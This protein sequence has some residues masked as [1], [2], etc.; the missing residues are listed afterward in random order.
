MIN[1][2]HRIAI[3]ILFAVCV[4]SP[5]VAYGAFADMEAFVEKGRA[6]EEEGDIPMAIGQY[7]VLANGYSEKSPKDE[8]RKYSEIFKHTG[9]LCV[10]SQRYVESLRFY[11]L[12]LQAA[13]QADDTELMMR[14]LGNIGNVYAMFDDF[15]RAIT[16]YSRCYR[17]ALRLD[18]P[19]LQAKSLYSLCSAYSFAGQVDKAMEALSKFQMLGD[20]GMEGFGYYSFILQGFIAEA[21]DNSRAALMLQKEALKKARELR[22]DSFT[23]VEQIWQVGNAWMNVSQPDSAMVCFRHITDIG[24]HSGKYYRTLMKAY[25][26]LSDI[27]RQKG[28]SIM[29]RE[30]KSLSVQIADSIFDFRNFQRTRNSLVEYEEMLSANRIADLSDRLTIYLIVFLFLAVILAT[31]GTFSLIIIKRNKQLKFANKMLVEKNHQLIQSEEQNR[32]YINKYIGAMHLPESPEDDKDLALDKQKAAYLDDTQYIILLT[33][34]RKALDDESML[35][36]P[37]F[38]LSMLAQIVK[39]N[40]KYVSYVINDTFGKNFKALLNEMRI[41]EATKRLEDVAGGYRLLTIQA[42]SESVGYRSQANFILS[43]KKIVGMP[44]AMYRKLAQEKTDNTSH[45]EP[46]GSDTSEQK[47][48]GLS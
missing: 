30:Y 48:Q 26:S 6:A 11:I 25:D 19:E 7:S 15:D 17:L 12:S 38:S 36:N 41:R 43:F 42:I 5:S 10:A 16:Y 23:V 33:R 37:D 34:I 2:Y 27:C 28:D 32:K 47:K 29:A 20:S 31:V 39:S 1:I 40:T 13:T 9:D 35:F 44:P 22:L 14:C 24:K 45:D 46:Q 3:F 8:Q 21:D 18:S 4:M